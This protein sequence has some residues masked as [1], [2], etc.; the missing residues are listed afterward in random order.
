[1]GLL[2]YFSHKSDA[3]KDRESEEHR[4]KSITNPQNFNVYDVIKSAGERGIE[5]EALSK[6]TGIE[7]SKTLN[8]IVYELQEANYICW[9]SQEKVM[10]TKYLS[11][12]QS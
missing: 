10:A 1:M 5:F 12:K 2:N 8:D 3:E 9:I 6:R 11:E 4:Q 7:L